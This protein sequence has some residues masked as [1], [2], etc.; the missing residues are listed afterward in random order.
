MTTFA[1]WPS[2]YARPALIVAGAAL[3]LL[4]L[5]RS[6][7]A[8]LLFFL[9]YGI[10]YLL[11]AVVGALERRRVPRWGGMV[12]ALLLLLVLFTAASFVVAGFIQQ[13][14][15]FV[16]RVPDLGAQL[17]AWY[18]AL[19]ELQRFVPPPLSAFAEGLGRGAQSGALE[20]ALSA[21]GE[22]AVRLSTGAFF[23]LTGL[24]GGVV[25]AVV[26]LF[27]TAFL[28]L[29]FDGFNRALLR[30]VPER[31]RAQVL[32]LAAK[33]D[34]SVGGYFQGRLVVS[35]IVALCI[36]A[37]MVLLGVP[38]ALG[39]AFLAGVFNL[40]PFLGPIIAF[41]PAG[42][43]ALTLGWVHL[44]ATALI[45]TAANFLDGNVLSPVILSRTVQVHP[46]VVLLSVVVGASAFGVLGVV[47]G[48]PVAAFLKLLY[49]DYYLTSRWYRLPASQTGRS[50]RQP[51][52]RTAP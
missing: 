8:W 11:N 31:Y 14:S 49:E 2:R 3:V 18:A 42:L 41:I 48:V 17:S 13:M 46:L 12:L 45:F 26:L 9:A 43:L 32:E 4:F 21:L 34:R 24:V 22:S 6:R 20:S 28:L 39:I 1:S 37:G 51:P 23:A 29:D 50:E 25:Q 35:F 16:A 52:R 15:E 19:N 40:V 36:W 5:Y 7:G 30:A 47:L 10:A 44:L 27:L 33:A 38:L